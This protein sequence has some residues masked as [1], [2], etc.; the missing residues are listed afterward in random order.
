VTAKL[1]YTTIIDAN[2][3]GFIPMYIT[4]RVSFNIQLGSQKRATTQVR[5]LPSYI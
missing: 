5:N 1:F 4:L 2:Y 3:K